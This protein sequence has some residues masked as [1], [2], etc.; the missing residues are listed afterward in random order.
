MSLWH[1]APPHH[2]ETG[3]VYF[4]TAGTLHK[5]RIFN[6]DEC[7]AY[8]EECLLRALDNGGWLVQAWAVLS[9]HYHFVA[10]APE[11]AMGLEPMLRG[12]HSETAR[13][14][15]RRDDAAGRQVWFQYRETPL[16]FERS[17]LARMNYVHQN[18]VHHGLVREA[19]QYPYCSAAWFEREANPGFYRAVTMTKTDRVNLYDDY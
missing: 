17:W 13:E 7:R 11:E 1:H 16:T 18:A 6:T 9:N 15:N 2:F 12:M 5:V 19:T 4:V 8:L 14:I 10:E 3:R